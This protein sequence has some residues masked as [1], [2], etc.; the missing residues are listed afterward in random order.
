MHNKLKYLR[1]SKNLSQSELAEMMG[2][3]RSCIS[4]WERGTRK[5][6]SL[7]IFKYY[8]IFKLPNNY[9]SPSVNENE[10]SSLNC[11]DVS[12]LNSKG[13]KKL[14]DFYLELVKKEEYLKKY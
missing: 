7:S 9:F 4:S 6:G 13:V 12:L 10:Y 2:I 14:Y 8:K 3:S 11:F 1:L 5:P